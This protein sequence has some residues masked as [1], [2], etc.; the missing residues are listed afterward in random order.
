MVFIS[1]SDNF[2]NSRIWC[3]SFESKRSSWTCVKYCSA[4][5]C[6]LNLDGRVFNCSLFQLSSR[7]LASRD[8]QLISKALPRISVTDLS[9]INFWMSVV[10]SL[11]SASASLQRTFSCC[12]MSCKNSFKAFP[13]AISM[14][15]FLSFCT[16]LP[17]MPFNKSLAQSLAASLAKSSR[18]G[19]KSNPAA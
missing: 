8:S 6:Q 1:I 12:C 4:K 5:N 15:S 18:M 14:S 3:N 10:Y 11:I 19:L 16:I 9:L 17:G 13:A 7:V 2:C